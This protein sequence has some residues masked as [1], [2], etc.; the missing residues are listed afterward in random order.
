MCASR[1]RNLFA[2]HDCR[3]ALPDKPEPLGPEMA[4]VDGA[5]S[6]SCDTLALTGAGSGPYGTVFRP[7]SETKR[8]RPAANACEEMGLPEPV[9]IGRPN[10]DD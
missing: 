1:T 4:G 5:L 7:S 10:I 2:K 6:L 3:A 9:Q 8:A